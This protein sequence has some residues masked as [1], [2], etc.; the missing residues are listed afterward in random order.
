ME[1]RALQAAISAPVGAATGV[2]GEFALPRLTSAA[3][4]LMGRKTAEGGYRLTPGQQFGGGLQ[5]FEGR[6]TS[7]PFTGELVGSTLGKP[8]GTF[9]RDA[10][11]T[12]LGPSLAAKL[13]KGLEG[14]ELVE[15]ASLIV[16]DAYRDIVPKISINDAPFLNKAKRILGAATKRLQPEDIT[17]VQAVMKDIYLPSV[18]DGKISTNLL[19]DLESSLGTEANKMIRSGDPA[20]RRQGR[21]FERNA[22]RFAGRDFPAKS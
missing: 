9:R 7:L 22:R 4:G 18:K 3:R 1:E 15:A 10:V 21:V 6:L 5:K 12:A 8:V 16:A 13:P 2:A 20:L 14:N 11:E 17:A 19:K